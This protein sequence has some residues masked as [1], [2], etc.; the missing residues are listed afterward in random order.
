MA[1]MLAAGSPLA[2]APQDQGSTPPSDQSEQATEGLGLSNEQKEKI[3][4][5]NQTRR[6]QVQAVQQ[7]DSL[8]REQKRDKIREINRNANQQIDQL[9]TAQQRE[10][11]RRR[12]QERREDHRDRQRDGRRRD[13]RD[14][15]RPP[16]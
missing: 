10:Q 16:L 8:T 3:K 9:L 15:Q 6:D 2:A 4:N 13:R 12:M 7:D 11:Y 1:L 14:G 5:I